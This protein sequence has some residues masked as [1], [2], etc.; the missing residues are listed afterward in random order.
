MALLKTDVHENI[1]PGP[2][3]SDE[4]LILLYYRTEHASLSEKST[5]K[6]EIMLCWSHPIII[7]CLSR[8]QNRA[9]ITNNQ[10]INDINSKTASIKANKS[11][12]SKINF[13]HSYC[14]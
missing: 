1:A 13:S 12:P 5:I 9:E 4:M 10:T 3:D 6:E 11:S 2:I 7:P 8:V 14:I